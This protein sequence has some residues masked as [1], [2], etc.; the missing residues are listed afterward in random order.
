MLVKTPLTFS[1]NNFILQKLYSLNSTRNGYQ[2]Y[3]L[4]TENWF[5]LF[6]GKFGVIH[7]SHLFSQWEK[8]PCRVTTYGLK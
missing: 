1:E 6:F 2:L 8:K 3:N 7:G 4:R 5:A